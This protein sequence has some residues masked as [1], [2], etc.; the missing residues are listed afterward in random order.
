MKGFYLSYGDY[1][2]DLFYLE[3]LLR[4]NNVHLDIFLKA[5]K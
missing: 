4:Q 5:R 2:V 1:Q 3:F